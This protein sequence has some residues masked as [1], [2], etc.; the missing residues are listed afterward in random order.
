[1]SLF[2]FSFNQIRMQS[3]CT[4]THIYINQLKLDQALW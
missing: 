4:N 3:V 2:H 1:M